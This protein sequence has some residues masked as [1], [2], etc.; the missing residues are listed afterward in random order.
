MKN[1]LV[2]LLAILLLLSVLLSGCAESQSS[3]ES[4]QATEEEAFDPYGAE[5]RYD[6]DKE[7]FAVQTGVDYGTVVSDLTY[8]S[9][10]AGDDKRCCVLLPAGY[11]ESKTYPVMYV[12]HTFGGSPDELIAEKSYLTVLYGNMLHSGLAVPMIIVAFDLY[13]GPAAEKDGKTGAEL[14]ESYN[15][16][17]EEIH[18]D[19]MPFIEKRFPVSTA[20]ED[21]AVAGTS[22]GAVKALCIGFTWPEEFGWIGS[23]SPVAGVIPSEFE[24]YTMWNEPAMEDF[25]QL[26]EEEAPCYVYLAVGSEDSGSTGPT[27]FY[28]DVLT[29][30]GIRNQTDL[31]DGFDHTVRFWKRCFYN[32]LAKAF[33]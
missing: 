5:N 32:F 20:R 21:T 25:P 28:G 18:A 17:I 2:L 31:V 13:T 33:Q 15:K 11:D 10:V 22:E 19:L 6:V 8:P 23:F 3:P 30:C 24:K 4:Q 27:L 29:E 16:V 26:A 7:M 14:R 1:A 12:A 9:T